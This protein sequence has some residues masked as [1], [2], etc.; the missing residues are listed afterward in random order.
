[1]AENEHYEGCGPVCEPSCADPDA[2]GCKDNDSCEEGCFC[3]DGYLREGQ[4]C[5]AQC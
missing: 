5:V 1:C 2:L 4:E 3:N